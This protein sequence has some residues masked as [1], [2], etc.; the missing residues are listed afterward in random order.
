M[1]YFDHSATTPI[2]E[3]VLELMHTIE[4]NQFGNPSSIHQ[5]GQQTRNVVEMARKQAADAIGAR[6]YDIVFTGGGTEANNMVLWN[7]LYQNKQHVITSAIEHPAILN[8]LKKLK[9]F[10]LSYDI[11]PVDKHGIVK[12]Y[13]LEKAIRP[14]TGLISIMLANNEVGSIQPLEQI[15]ALARDR[16][17]PVHSDAVQALGKIPVNVKKLDIDFL[18]FSAHKFYGPKGTGFLYIRKGRTVKPHVIGGSQER[19]MRAGTENVPGIAGLGLAAQLAA[20][21]VE[22]SGKHLIKLANQFMSGI[23]KGCP[24]V[25][26][27]GHPEKHLPG[28]VSMT[29]PGVTSDVLMIR[30]DRD[31][32]AISNGSACSSGTIE[33]SHVLNAMKFRNSD[34]ISTLRISFGKDN[35]SKDV[36]FLIKKLTAFIQYYRNKQ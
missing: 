30:L 19:K 9:R 13:K 16:T 27:N 8:V 29:V 11:I 35:N 2:R 36:D 10:G 17:I 31:D 12:L 25:K 28:L 21:S 34:N 5:F 1:Y 33:P 22:K 20:E 32:I 7:L 26:F 24:Y 6:S 23:Q 14:D 3:E 18:T 4:S 15:V